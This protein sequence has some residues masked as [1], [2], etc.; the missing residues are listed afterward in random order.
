MSPDDVSEDVQKTLVEL[1]RRGYKLAI[2][3]SSKNTP[4][5]LDRLG[6]R[7]AFD[8]VAD[9]NEIK[10]SKPNPEVFLLAAQKLHVKPEN[11]IVVEDAKVGIMAAKA[12][13]MSA[14]S[15][16]GDARNCNLEDYNLDTLQNLL[17]I[18]PQSAQ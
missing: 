14:F 16:Y 12:A 8:V 15:L 9:G 10:H 11:C 7:S 13:G 4:L 18:L 3:S 1:R 17:Q 2:G 5:I 6:I